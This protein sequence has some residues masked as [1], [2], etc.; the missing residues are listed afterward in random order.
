MESYWKMPKPKL[1]ISVTG[2]AKRFYLKNRLR[3]NFKRGLVNVATT[4]GK[5]VVWF[6]SQVFFLLLIY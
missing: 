4:T 3:N 6:D 2:G 1:I 5:P